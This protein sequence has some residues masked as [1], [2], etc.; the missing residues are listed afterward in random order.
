MTAY[1][2]PIDTTAVPCRK[3]PESM[4]PTSTG[5]HREAQE[6]RAKTVCRTGANGGRCPIFDA[7]LAEALRFDVVGI[8]GATTKE[9]RDEIRKRTGAA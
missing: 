4:F 1:P 2:A 5:P 8:W 3:D 7:C 9:E 6:N